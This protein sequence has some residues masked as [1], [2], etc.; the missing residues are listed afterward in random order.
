VCLSVIADITDIK[1]AEEKVRES[2]EVW[3]EI[4]RLGHGMP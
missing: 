2:Q 3:K 4:V 1:S